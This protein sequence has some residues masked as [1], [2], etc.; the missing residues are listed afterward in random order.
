MRQNKII[1]NMKAKIFK[2]IQPAKSFAASQGPFICSVNIEANTKR[3]AHILLK[4]LVDDLKKQHGSIMVEIED[5]PQTEN[6]LL[7]INEFAK[8]VLSVSKGKELEDLPKILPTAIKQNEQLKNAPI[9]N[10]LRPNKHDFEAAY[11]SFDNEEDPEPFI[12]I[13]TPID[14][15][16]A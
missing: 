3:E 10:F 11:V 8:C 9:L 15:Y 2:S 16:K 1:S 7:T 6:Y 4:P 13:L 14:V 12:C 5:K